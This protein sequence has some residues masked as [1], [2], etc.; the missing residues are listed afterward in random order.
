MAVHRGPA[1]G[2]G[3]SL[4]G[5]L[6]LWAQFPVDADQRPL[7]LIGPRLIEAG[8]TTRQAQQAFRERNLT[9]GPGV[10][11]R[12]VAS[13][14]AAAGPLSEGGCY[15]LVVRAGQPTRRG[16]ATDRG[17]QTLKAWSLTV[18][19][20]L[21]P[22]VVLDAD[23]QQRIWS[24]AEGHLSGAGEVAGVRADLDVAGTRLRYQ[25]YGSPRR[26][27]DY[28]GAELATSRTAVA[29]K[30]HAGNKTGGTG[31]QL[32]YAERREVWVDLPTPLGA[33]VL[34]DAGGRPI[35]AQTRSH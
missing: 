2:A 32:L 18:T 3:E 16:F 21:A 8:Y 27:T 6:A 12:A 23:E 34:I 29:I 15:G 7:V 25:F 35:Q 17:E 22:L 1:A 11:V 9:V 13:L 19:G 33:R 4:S 20:S 24:P 26:C 14:L 31:N 5:A 10:P 30:P 28:D